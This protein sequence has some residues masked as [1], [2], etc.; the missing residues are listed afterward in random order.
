MEEK[1]QG[2]IK[3]RFELI[4]RELQNLLAFGYVCLIILGMMFEI[5]YYSF[6][7]IN[8]FEYAGVS[9]FLL[10][11][12]RRPVSLMILFIIGVYLMVTYPMD[13]WMAKNWP[14]FYRILN[15][16]IVKA[17]R[18]SV[19][20]NIVFV[21]TALTLIILLS[22]DQGSKGFKKVQSGENNYHVIFAEN[23]KEMYG[24]KVGQT[25]SY[26]FL[27]DSIEQIKV[28]PINSQVLLME[29]IKVMR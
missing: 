27:M 17:E 15:F 19:Y 11:P 22:V 5:G 21:F 3:D 23:Q 7:G 8:I 12:F 4:I 1:D 2:L 9:D 26:L 16:G 13:V 14:R 25:S 6:F 18:S 29:P 28:I 10:A 20:R 24:R